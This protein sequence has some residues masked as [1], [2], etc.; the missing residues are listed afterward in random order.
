MN[1]LEITDL[2][3]TYP[4]GTKALDGVSLTIPHHART[5][6][7]GANGSG[8]STLLLHTNG[9]LP[10]K[11]GRVQVLGQEW[12]GNDMRRLRERVG[13]VF[14]DPDDQLFATTVADDVAFGP[15]NLGLDEST[16]QERV[17]QALNELEILDLAHR[18]PH[19]LSLGQKKRAAIAGVLAM[20]PEMLV[21]DEPTASL[22]PLAVRHLTTLL[23]TLHRQ[24]RT[25]ILATHNVDFAYQWADQ[26]IILH[27]GQVLASGDITLLQDEALL[28][29]ASLEP[30]LLLQVF[31]DTP[32]RPRNTA[33][34]NQIIRNTLLS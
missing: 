7:L 9:L 22:D 1:A 11:R 12:A 32:H 14:Q 29:K 27:R 6:L 13:M 8:K 31:R 16:V 4:D 26:V 19:N 25:I 10:P 18:P 3:Y 33:E 20:Q 5:V 28:D 24:G 15:R 17:H 34:A 2:H 30:P 21:L 23:H